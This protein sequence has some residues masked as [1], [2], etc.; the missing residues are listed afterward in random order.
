M[1]HKRICYYT[2][3]IRLFLLFCLLFHYLHYLLF[4][5]HFLLQCEKYEVFSCLLV[6]PSDS[7]N[8]HCSRCQKMILQHYPSWIAQDPL[9]LAG[10]VIQDL[11]LMIHQNLMIWASPT[12][13]SDPSKARMSW[14][15]CRHDAT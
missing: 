2:R 5:F 4:F 14:R 6:S 1:K 8:H 15:L 3:L 9:M 7:Q 13:L 10:I 11:Y 12:Q